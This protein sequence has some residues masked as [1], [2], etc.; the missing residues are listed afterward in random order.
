MLLKRKIAGVNAGSMADIAFLLLIF[1]LVTT[2]IA[3]DEGLLITLPPASPPDQEPLP[4]HDRNLFSI[5][6]N[7]QDELLVEGERRADTRGLRAELQ[8]F[9]LNRGKEPT[10]SDSPQKAVVSIKTQS[11]TSYG[12]FLHVLDEAQAAYY[13]LYAGRVGLSAEAYRQLDRRDP[14]MKARYEQGKAG[15]P[16]NIS[17]ANP[18]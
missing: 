10:S 6:L 9:I 1:F 7:S 16:M 2:V 18:D 12:Q 15:L 8:A 11:G 4:L 5:R 14:A 13:E 17:I 3:Q